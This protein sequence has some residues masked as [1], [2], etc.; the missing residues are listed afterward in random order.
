MLGGLGWEPPSR[1]GSSSARGPSLFACR[2][3]PG[4]T[5][6]V[7]S[8]IHAPA[9][10]TKSAHLSESQTAVFQPPCGRTLSVPARGVG[11]LHLT[12][13]G[14]NGQ[15]RLPAGETRETRCSEGWA[16]NP[17]HALVP[18]LR[19]GH[20]SSH[21]ELVPDALAVSPVGSTLRH[22]RQSP[23]TRHLRWGSSSALRPSQ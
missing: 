16:G 21:A 14:R 1:A 18:H 4:C 23:P 5:C 19:E 2:T 6:R 3:C 12:G 22:P 8:R 15:V 17:H 20:P 7:A 9:S 13:R 11:A 10:E